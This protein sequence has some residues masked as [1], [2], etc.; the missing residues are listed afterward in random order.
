MQL[1][2]FE[3]LYLAPQNPYPINQTTELHRHIIQITK[4]Q[5]KIIQMFNQVSK[6]LCQI[7]KMAIIATEIHNT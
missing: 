1:S 2:M 6:L 3:S 7:N 4:L 5:Y